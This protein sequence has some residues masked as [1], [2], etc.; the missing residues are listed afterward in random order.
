MCT[1]S[2]LRRSDGYLLLCN[3]DERHTRKP[4]VGP[5]LAE[6]SGVSLL[7]P[8]DGD[9]GGSWIGVN[10]FGLTLCLLNRYGDVLTEHNGPFTSRGLLLLELLDC[11]RSPQVSER[12][13]SRDLKVFPPFTMVALA[14]EEPAMVI[15][16]TG[17]G[18]VVHTDAESSMPITSSSMKGLD[19]VGDRKKQFQKLAHAK[20]LDARLLYEFHRSHLPVRGPSSVCMHRDDAATVSLSAVDV[21]PESIEFSYYGGPPCLETQVES[22]RLKRTGVEVVLH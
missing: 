16:W 11:A 12:V 9:Y 7:A 4:A 1:V 18:C 3:R 6:R 22:V 8:V 15:E 2:W 21:S 19:V 14:V 10:Q 5:R 20:Q 17:A 13:S